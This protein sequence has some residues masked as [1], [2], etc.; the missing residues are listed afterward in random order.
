MT[1]VSIPALRS[2]IDVPR[3]AWFA[4]IA[5][6]TS[7]LWIVFHDEDARL[8][9]E[10]AVADGFDDAAQQVVVDFEDAGPLCGS[11]SQQGAT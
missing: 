6:V 8:L 3:W 7:V 2:R 1:A 4:G 5:I 10:L 9:P 11:R